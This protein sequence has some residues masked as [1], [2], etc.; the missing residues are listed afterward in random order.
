MKRRELI[1]MSAGTLLA[2]GLWPG[3]LN[4]AETAEATPESNEPWRFIAVNDLHCM[5]AKCRPWFDQVVAA[6]KQETPDARFCLIC[7]DL[8][9]GGTEWQIR[10]IKEAFAALDMPVFVT[11]GNHDYITDTDSSGFEAVYPGPRNRF[12][13]VR[14]WQFVGLDSTDGTRWEKT[15]IH[16]P[17]FAWLDENLPKLSRTKPTVIY[18]HFP[19][20]E[21]AKYRPLNADALLENFLDF[22]LQ[23]VL[24]GHWHAY[25]LTQFHDASCTTNRCCSRVRDNHDDTKEKGWFVCEIEG[26]K[27]NR[28]FIEIPAI[29]RGGKGH[30]S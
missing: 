22:N 17:T 1:K 24:S 10:N 14:G 5:E 20:G 28:R 9:D 29:L 12:F 11:P 18:T 4:A 30:S 8:A 27:L 15:S 26:G 21:G 3:Q 7:G 23:A 19:M 2:A 16:A 6:M 25:T 13:E